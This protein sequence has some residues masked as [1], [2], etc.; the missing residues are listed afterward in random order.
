MPLLLHDTFTGSGSLSGAVPDTIGSA[1]T[2]TEIWPDTSSGNADYYLGTGGSRRRMEKSSGSASPAGG[3]ITSGGYGIFYKAGCTVP[4]NFDLEVQLTKGSTYSYIY[5]I[6]R[7]NLDSLSPP[8]KTN[9]WAGVYGQNNATYWTLKDGYTT[10]TSTLSSGAMASD[11]VLKFEI[12]GQ[13]I[14]PYRNGTVNTAPT[15]S[16]MPSSGN[17]YIGWGMIW[18]NSVP[19]AYMGDG[20]ATGSFNYIKIADPGDL[21]YVAGGFR[22]RIIGGGCI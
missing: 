5:V 9:S 17:V 8:G 18:N 15:F 6:W 7:A 11:D 22:G 21:N 12:R 16:S 10:T 13:V 1:W 20:G 19:N 2:T 14:T 3:N 4:N